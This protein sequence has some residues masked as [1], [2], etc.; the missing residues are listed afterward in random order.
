MQHTTG[1]SAAPE[2]T[3]EP[4]AQERIE[5]LRLVDT[6]HLS[7]GYDKTIAPYSVWITYRRETGATEHTWHANVSGYRVLA[8]GVVDMNA[9]TS[10][11]GARPTGT[12]PRTG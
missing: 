7:N 11:C 6:P 3:V 2:M 8:N 12:S 4:F 5:I 10:S 9:P 1:T